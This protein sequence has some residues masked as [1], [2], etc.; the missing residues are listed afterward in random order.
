MSIVETE[1]R[2]SHSQRGRWERV[3]NYSSNC[4]DFESHLVS[5]I[6]VKHFFRN[7]FS[8][9]RMNTCAHKIISNRT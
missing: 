8:K 4:S 6:Q 1:F 7:N 9:S 3:Q 5:S 2:E